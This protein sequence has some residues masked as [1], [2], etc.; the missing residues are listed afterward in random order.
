MNTSDRPA[1]SLQGVSKFFYRHAGPVLL[2]DRISRMFRPGPR[3]RLWALR[4]VSFS[5]HPGES[6]A[7]IGS[8]GAG[9]STLL[10]IATGL[11]TPSE[12]KVALTGRVAALLELGSGFHGDLTGAE[13]VRTNAAL[14]GLSRAEV[15]NRFDSIV[16]FSGIADF[17]D[18]P[19]RTYSTGMVMRLAFSVAV[20]VDPDILIIDEVLGVGDQAFFKKCFDRIMEFRRSGKTILCVSHSLPTL[21][22]LCNRAVWLDHGRVLQTGSVSQVIRAYTA[23]MG[24]PV[25]T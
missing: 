19:I 1:V 4:D 8:N 5:V 22:Q 9:K 12:G 23:S 14:L 20:N 2:R 17:I 13:N 6:L 25:R 15:R 11:C 3:E 10:N 16:E 21:E 18:E 24:V 7:V